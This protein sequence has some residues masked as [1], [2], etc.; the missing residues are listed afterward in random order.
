MSFRSTLSVALL[1]SALVPLAARSETPY[2]L[3]PIVVTATRTPLPLNAI[4]Q[5]TIVITRKEI[6]ESGASTVPGLLRFYAGLDV[7]TSGGP[8]QPSSV[9][10]RGANSAQTLVLINGVKVNGGNIGEPP[11]QNL[12]L[13]DIQRIV[14]VEGPTAALYG[15]DG[16]GGVI[17]I[18]TR[19]SARRVHAHVGVGGG[20]FRTTGES[21]GIADGNGTVQGGANVSHEV[22]DGFP[23]QTASPLSAGFTNTTLNAFLRVRIPT[24]HLELRQWQST[25]QT[26]YVDFNLQPAS[27]DYNDRILS[28]AAQN[29]LTSGWSSEWLI[30]RYENV[31]NQNQKDVFNPNQSPDFALTRR[32]AA[33]WQNNFVL[34]GTDL[35]TA[36]ISLEDERTASLVFGTAYDAHTWTRSIYAENDWH[37][38]RYRLLATLRHSDN[39]SFG[40]H[41]E[42]N[43]GGTVFLTPASRITV[44]WGSGFR[45]PSAEDRFGFGGNPNLAPESSHEV[46]LGF[47]QEMGV[48]GHWGIDLFQDTITNLIV[49]LGP[50]AQYPEGINENV[51]QARIRGVDLSYGAGFGPWRLRAEAVLQDPRDLVSGAQLARRAKRSLTTAL[52]YHWAGGYAGIEWLASGPRPDSPYTTTIDPGYVVTDAVAGIDLSRHWSL[53]ASLVNLFNVRYT[54][55]AGYNTEGRAVFFHV[56]WHY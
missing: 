37:W 16:I 1:L 52:H 3:S 20:R 8:G 32:Y 40:S 53:Q 25:G 56:L 29:Q 51:D 48:Y 17:D 6:R 33:D 18:I 27:E 41:N 35:V 55:V 43:L 36:G 15:S 49:Y 24:G 12:M 11:L 19:G 46:D 50:T 7:A 44:S 4:P 13:D 34:S 39:E 28:L 54:Q 47:H 38:H 14:I 22:T 31:L 26:D 2:P 23:P 10:I 21:A 5:P 45:A 9:F 30:S 42:W